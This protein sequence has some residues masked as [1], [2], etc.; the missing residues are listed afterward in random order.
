MAFAEERGKDERAYWHAGGSGA[1]KRQKPKKHNVDL[2]FSK[3]F[4]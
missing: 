3:I 4:S 2:I 1:I